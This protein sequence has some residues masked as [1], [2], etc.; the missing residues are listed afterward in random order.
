MAGHE[1][2]LF[3][4][5]Q[6]RYN[7]HHECITTYHVFRTREAA[8]A[9]Q[10]KKERNSKTSQFYFVYDSVKWGPDN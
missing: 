8:L 7:K 3:L 9:F 1:N 5:R 4:I 10:K 6:C 2:R